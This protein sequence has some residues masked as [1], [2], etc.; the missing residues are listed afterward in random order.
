MR[1]DESQQES[2]CREFLRGRGSN[3]KKGLYELG[4]GILV[5]RLDTLLFLQEVTYS[6]QAYIYLIK[7]VAYFINLLYLL[8]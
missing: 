7:I 6:H 1:V 3:V 5:K 8:N 4:G 2:S